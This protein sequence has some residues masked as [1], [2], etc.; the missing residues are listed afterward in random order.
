MTES[1]TPRKLR[2]SAYWTILAAA[3]LYAFFHFG[4]VVWQATRDRSWLVDEII[5]K[6]YAA[7]LFC[8]RLDSL[9]LA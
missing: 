2:R 6:P 9:R 4:F 5:K 7:T 3:L 1:E 8:R